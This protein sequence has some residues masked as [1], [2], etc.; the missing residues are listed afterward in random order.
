MQDQHLKAM[1][2]YG[3]FMGISIVSAL[4]QDGELA[5]SVGI[6][7]DAERKGIL[8]APNC[9]LLMY[10]VKDPGGW[11]VPNE[12]LAPVFFSCISCTFLALTVLS[13]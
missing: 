9:Q 3:N 1:A 12:H 8:K 11:T 2:C 7:S 4:G 10:M 13:G 6:L 5:D